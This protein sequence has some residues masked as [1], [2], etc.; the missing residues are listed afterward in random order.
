VDTRTGQR[1]SLGTADEDEARQIIHAKNQAARQP[2]LNLELARAY[3][4][5]SDSATARRTWSDVMAG[6][7]NEVLIRV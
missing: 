7:L 4:S 2:L 5:G 1:T 3:L 6:L